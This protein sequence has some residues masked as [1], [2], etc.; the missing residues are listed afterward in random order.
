MNI[1]VQY[2]CFLWSNKGFHNRG[3]VMDVVV[4][5]GCQEC[6]G[7]GSIFWKFQVNMFIFFVSKW[8]S[9]IVW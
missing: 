9:E 6:C 3:F 5:L 4:R 8:V 7:C 2:R 1:S